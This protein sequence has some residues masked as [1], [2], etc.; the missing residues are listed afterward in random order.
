MLPD[1]SDVIS[2]AGE[3]F[4]DVLNNNGT[5][6]LLY[7]QG[8]VQPCVNCQ[9]DPIGKK[10]AN[11]WRTGGPLSF[12]DGTICPQCGGA[13]TT[14]TEYTDSIKLTIDHNLSGSRAKYI[15]SM[16]NI[17]NPE[18]I[19]RTRGFIED[20]P[21]IQKTIQMMINDEKSKYNQW[22]YQ[23]ASEPFDDM[24]FVKNKFF[25]MFWVRC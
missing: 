17:R 15:T 22:K 18:S 19:I 23:P 16:P 20:I 14:V 12:P 24:V 10:S 13:G 8:L 5:T 9:F 25:T 4:T 2:G 21:K 6:C 3:A 11:R 1:F 7:F